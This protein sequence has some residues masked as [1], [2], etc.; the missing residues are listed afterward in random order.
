MKQ[1]TCGI[2]KA[3]SN[4]K[5]TVAMNLLKEN[6]GEDLPKSDFQ[7]ILEILLSSLAFLNLR[8]CIQNA[9]TLPVASVSCE[10]SFS[11]LRLLKT[12]LR[13]KTQDGRLSDLAVLFVHMQCVHVHD[14]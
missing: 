7:V 13:N 14:L 4:A 2:N 10:R 5:M 11:A 8:K 6:L 12:H 3:L 1:L 9:L